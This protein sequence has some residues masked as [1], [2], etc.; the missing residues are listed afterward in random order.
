M[1]GQVA[2]EVPGDHE[3]EG[4]DASV[5][6]G[7]STA[8]TFSPEEQQFLNALNEDLQRFN[9]YFI[10]KEEEAV[11]KLQDISDQL[12]QRDASKEELGRIKS[13][14]VDFHGN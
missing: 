11:I 2:G 7:P 9:S 12:N 10:D 1:T 6:T 3:K 4:A 13:R 14:L 5:S 8:A